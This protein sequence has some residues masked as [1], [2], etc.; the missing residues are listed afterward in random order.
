LSDR[1][2]LGEV[3]MEWADTNR[4]DHGSMAECLKA[5]LEHS[6][7]Q[8]MKVFAPSQA[9]LDEVRDLWERWFEEGDIG[10]LYVYRSP[11]QAVW[12]IRQK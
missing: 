7:D 1:L 3:R 5:F 10:E 11:D 8:T 12:C 9:M 6:Q 2:W 4:A